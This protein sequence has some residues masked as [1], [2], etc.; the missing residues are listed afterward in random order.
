LRKGKFLP[1]SEKLYHPTPQE[2]IKT[3]SFFLDFFSVPFLRIRRGS[4]LKKAILAPTGKI[5]FANYGGSSRKKNIFAKNKTLA[6]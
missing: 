2:S 3:P 6:G 5:S 4:F 1:Y